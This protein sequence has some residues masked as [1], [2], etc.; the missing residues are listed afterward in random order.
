VSGSNTTLILHPD[1]RDDITF[2]LSLQTGASEGYTVNVGTLRFS[3]EKRIEVVYGGEGGEFP[4]A[5]DETS[6]LADVTFTAIISSATWAGMMGKLEAFQLAVRN[7]A[8]GTL[9]YKPEGAAA[10]TRSTFYHYVQ[11]P[12]PALRQRAKNRPDRGANSSGLFRLE[13][14]VT[15]RTWP[16]AT[17]DPD[18]LVE[19]L[20]ATTLH[21]VGDGSQDYVTVDG[22]DIKGSLP[23]L[24]RYQV[25]PSAGGAASIERFWLAR[26]TE[27]LDNLAT[28]YPSSDSAYINT[29][30]AWSTVVDADRCGGSYMRCVP[31]HN[32]TEYGRRFTLSNWSDHR[33]RAAVAVITR[34]NAHS[35]LDWDIRYGWPY[36]AQVSYGS[37]KRVSQTHQ[38]E[39]RL[40]GEFDL[41]DTEMSDV[42]DINLYV[43]VYVK[44][45][46]GTSKLD[47]DGVKL[48]YTDE[49]AIE[50][51]L[52]L[53]EGV[54][55]S[56]TLLLEH[57]SDSE[58]L[59]V[60]DG[61]NKMTHLVSAYGNV[62]AFLPGQNN[63]LDV[64]WHRYKATTIKETFEDYDHFWEQIAIFEGDESWIGS[65]ANT[66]AYEY[67]CQDGAAS[68]SMTF[69]GG[70]G[71]M[72]GTLPTPINLGAFESGD[73]IAL[74]CN[75]AYYSLPSAL[76]VELRLYSSDDSYFSYTFSPTIKAGPWQILKATLSSFSEHE[77]PSWSNIQSVRIIGTYTSG[78]QHVLY[79]DD[80]RACKADP[81]DAG[82]FNETG[83]AWNGDA[84]TRGH[85]ATQSG[86]TYYY[87]VEEFGEMQADVIP[88][89]LEWASALGFTDMMA[90]AKV[91][92]D[93]ASFMHAGIWLRA[94]DLTYGSEDGYLFS[95]SQPVVTIQEHT[96]SFATDL[97]TVVY[98]VPSRQWFWIGAIAHGGNLYLFVSRTKE[99]L[100]RPETLVCETTDST[101]TGSKCGLSV[102][103]EG[104]RISHFEVHEIKDQ[105]VPGDSTSIQAHALFRTIYPFYE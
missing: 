36:G 13:V 26:R 99:D 75:L 4:V 54:S 61:S 22:D 7:V 74:A 19:V 14:D 72:V 56:E 41:P 101:H 86:E 88:V 82:E 96:A 28:T 5:V 37:I 73:Y 49:A 52:P 35:E 31:E 93:N 67:I 69:S 68:Q 94:S 45:K 105:H 77:T 59:H 57:L 33:G 58:V 89:P 100:F 21:N 11:S 17:S 95:F 51:F 1:G 6:N 102:S 90:W 84:V 47:I 63:R 62:P 25:T 76:S 12:V 43:D 71:D 66:D 92:V 79:L 64:M 103:N 55:D 3:E 70:A 81:D 44:R 24:M 27:G 78:S 40:L 97:D 9:E 30:S 87:S 16:I 15:L 32:E 65:T 48:L 53:G 104:T 20:S 29:S 2:D 23:A 10:G 42:E 46:R 85:I 83:I 91:W 50:A 8:G 38:W 39:A 34:S 18:S 60:I 98:Q 80:L